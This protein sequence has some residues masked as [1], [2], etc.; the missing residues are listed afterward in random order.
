MLYLLNS[1]YKISPV[2]S[3]YLHKPSNYLLSLGRFDSTVSNMF[4]FENVVCFL[5]L[6]HIIKCT[7]DYFSLETN[8]MDP[9]Q[10]APVGAV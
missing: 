7:T 3:K 4:L 10:T 1:F 6:M 8:T 9:D 5:H 2:V